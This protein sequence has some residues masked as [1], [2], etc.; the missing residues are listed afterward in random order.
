MTS[1]SDE[2]IRRRA[3]ELWE[4]EGRP[5]GRH[6]EHWRQA[7]E[8]GGDGADTG[9]APDAM[10]E[11]VSPEATPAPARKTRSRS[12]KSAGPA[13][14]AAAPAPSEAPAPETKR[15]ARRTTPETG[16]EAPIRPAA[17]PRKPRSTPAQ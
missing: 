9:Q 2:D 12:A 5:H 1:K 11:A 15:R 7:L 8:H 3:Y 6:E 10:P 14:E 16:G 17:R 4:K 13:E